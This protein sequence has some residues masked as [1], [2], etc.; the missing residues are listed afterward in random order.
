MWDQID[1]YMDQRRRD[2]R[3]K[4]LKEELEKYRC[5]TLLAC[6]LTL[7]RPAWRTVAQSQLLCC[8]GLSEP[9][10]AL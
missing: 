4:I 3:E 10:S 7:S 1:E 2:R 5:S 9:A 8:G 6:S